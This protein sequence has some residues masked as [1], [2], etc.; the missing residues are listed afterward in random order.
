MPGEDQPVL[1]SATCHTDACPV[2]GVTFTGVPMYPTPEAKIYNAVCGQ[3]GKAVTDIV[4][5]TP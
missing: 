4:P 3:C 2:S 1:V 5:V